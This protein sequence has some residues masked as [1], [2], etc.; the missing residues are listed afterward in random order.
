MSHYVAVADADAIAE[1]SS[2]VFTIDDIRVAVCRVE[3]E[4]YAFEDVCT[5]DDAPLGEGRLLGFEIECPRHGARFDVR[6]GH[7]TRMPAVA[8]LPTF[9]VKVEGGRILVDLEED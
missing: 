5:H 3:G 2:K 7:V 1:G 6:D 8:P 4:Y 9:P